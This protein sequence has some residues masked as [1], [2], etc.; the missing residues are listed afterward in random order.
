MIDITSKFETCYVEKIKYLYNIEKV[1]ELWHQWSLYNLFYKI[2][3]I[4]IKLYNGATAHALY[5]N[6]TWNDTFKIFMKLKKCNLN[7]ET[8]TQRNLFKFKTIK[9]PKNNNKK[10]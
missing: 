9:K 1:T 5:G 8:I 2:R 7:W 4:K 10:Y 3:H 6:K